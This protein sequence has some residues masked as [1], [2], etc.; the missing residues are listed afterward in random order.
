GRLTSLIKL[1]RELALAFP[2]IENDPLTSDGVKPLLAS[3]KAG[4]ALQDQLI[5]LIA[6]EANPGVAA[7]LNGA[8]DY[9]P[10]YGSG[11]IRGEDGT[12]IPPDATDYTSGTN[13]QKGRAIAGSPLLRAA[14]T[15][16]ANAFIRLVEN[17]VFHTRQQEGKLFREHPFYRAAYERVRRETSLTP[18]SGAIAGVYAATDRSRGVWKAPANV[19][20]K[21]VS[22]PAVKLAD[23]EQES[24]N[25]HS[26]GKSI[27][28]I[29]EFTGKGTLVWGARTLE[30]NSNEWRYI[31]VRRFFNMVEE[32][33]KKASEPFVF[34][35]NDARTWIKVQAMIE[36]FLTLQWRAGALAGAKP[37]QAFYVKVGL[38]QTMTA[39]DILEGRMIIEIGMAVVRP[40][41]FIVLRFS[42]KMQE[43]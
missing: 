42:H 22:G 10:L 18:P 1:A 2:L 11:W 30:G 40:A 24:L 16:I 19:R 9:T 8:A 21:S 4:A 3:L 25:V 39:V 26:T 17:A 15:E 34:E 38:G 33:A 28:A 14:F 23:R 36:N 5:N 35:S 32:S 12:T 20:L 37:E 31:N 29:R 27:N 43:S 13:L 6:L 7:M 41:E